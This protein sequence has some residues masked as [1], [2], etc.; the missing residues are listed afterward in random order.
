[1]KVVC[2]VPNHPG[3]VVA[4]G[5]GGH[6]VDRRQLEGCEVDYVWVHATPKKTARARITN[7]LS[8]AASATMVGARRGPADVIIASSPPLPVGSVGAA[9]AMWW[10]PRGYIPGIDE[11]KKRLA[12]LESEGPSQFAFNFKNVFPPDES[13]LENFDWSIFQRCA[14]RAG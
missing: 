9:L 3:G 8:Y 7:Y 4:P 13:Y 5:Y 12:H 6:L 2:E 1:M 11:A 10:V 14:L